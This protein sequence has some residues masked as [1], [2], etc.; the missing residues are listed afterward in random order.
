LK[1]CQKVIQLQ[2][3]FD[4]SVTF[5][6]D[7][8]EPKRLEILRNGIIVKTY[9]AIES[10]DF[11]GSEFSS[12]FEICKIEF[13][14]TQS[15]IQAL[16]ELDRF[17]D[18]RLIIGDKLTA[19]GGVQVFEMLPN[20]ANN[21]TVEPEV[22]CILPYFPIVTDEA[23]DNGKIKLPDLEPIRLKM[24]ADNQVLAIKNALLT[25]LN[26]ETKAANENLKQSVLTLLELKF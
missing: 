7:S 16:F 19:C 10:G 18:F 6:T 2:K 14:V 22:T 25:P 8:N 11:L 9:F 4:K 24:M 21:Q 26:A 20:C 13:K 3:G 15:D 17:F 5:N 12:D 1:N 23:L